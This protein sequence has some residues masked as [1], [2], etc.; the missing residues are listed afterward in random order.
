MFV[1]NVVSAAAFQQQ[2]Q[3]LVAAQTG[4]LAEPK[5]LLAV[6]GHFPRLLG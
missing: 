5:F 3:S 6:W 2:Q 1:C 4:G